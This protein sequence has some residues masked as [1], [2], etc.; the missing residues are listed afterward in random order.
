MYKRCI[1]KRGLMSYAPIDAWN[2]KAIKDKA[3]KMYA[4]LYANFARFEYPTL[5]NRGSS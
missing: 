5:S 4:Q 2:N 3:M 1:Y